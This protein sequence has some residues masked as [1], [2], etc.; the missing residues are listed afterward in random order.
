MTDLV[1]FQ[2]DA[3]EID[4]FQVSG[5]TGD[6]QGAFQRCAFQGDAFQILRA[7]AF[8]EGS[9]QINAFQIDDC[10]PTPVETG[11]RIYIF[12]GTDGILRHNPNAGRK[13][14][15]PGGLVRSTAL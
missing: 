12:S 14:I 7:P 2:P 10:S 3:F 5:V 15:G 6:T 8:Q 11:A 13:N 1:A 4:A 9:F